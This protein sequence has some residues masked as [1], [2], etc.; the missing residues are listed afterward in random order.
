[1]LKR[2][3]KE[4]D[5]SIKSGI[6]NNNKIDYFYKTKKQALKHKFFLKKLYF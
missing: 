2:E 4:I 6:F 3:Y 1:M 5:W